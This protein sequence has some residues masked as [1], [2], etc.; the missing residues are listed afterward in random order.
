MLLGMDTVC[1]QVDMD[2]K[3]RLKSG[4]RKGTIKRKNCVIII[5]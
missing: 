4:R 5:P 1:R 3:H 2:A